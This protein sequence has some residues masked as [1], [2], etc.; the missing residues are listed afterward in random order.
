[1]FSVSVGIKCYCPQCPGNDVSDINYNNGTC[2]VRPGGVCFSSVFEK[3]DIE[4]N[5]YDERREYGCISDP[6]HVLLQCKGADLV[7]SLNRASIKCCNFTDLCNKNLYP[8]LKP[9]RMRQTSNKFLSD[10]LLFWTLGVLSV[11]I[12][13]VYIARL[14]HK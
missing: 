8:T 12:I 1:M 11:L 2:D 5:E 3:Y 10:Y 9:I 14:C 6:D 13:L 7:P 4:N